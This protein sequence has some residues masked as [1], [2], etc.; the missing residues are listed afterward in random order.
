[1][2]AT[3]EIHA[4]PVAE[5]VDTNSEYS[6]VEDAVWE[7]ATKIKDNNP[8]YSSVWS[9]LEQATTKSRIEESTLININLFGFRDKGSQ[10]MSHC[11][12]A[13]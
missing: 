3:Y 6:M 12:D 7:G 1:M 5:V 10:Y 4:D 2:Y 9:T 8:Y 13:Y 11:T